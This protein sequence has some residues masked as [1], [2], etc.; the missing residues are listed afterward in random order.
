MDALS[1]IND[2]N[3]FLSSLGISDAD[4]FKMM[5]KNVCFDSGQNKDSLEMRDSE[6][7]GKGVFAIDDIDLDRKWLASFRN[8]KYLCGRV[9]NHSPDPNCKF[10][11]EGDYVFCVPIKKIEAGS[12]LFVN[13]RD[14]VNLESIAIYKQPTEIVEF[15]SKVPS[16]ADWE[17]SSPIDKI[18]YELSTMPSGELPL[19][20]I[21]TEGIYI[22]KAL[23]PAGSIFTT[24][25]HNTEH[26][27][28]LISGT[29]QVISNDGAFRITG[30]F[31]GITKKGTRRLVYAET[32]SVYFTIHANPDN[33]TDPDEIVRK[34]TI[35]IDNPLMD[36]DDP[37]FNT[38]K[39]DI[40]PSQSISTII[41]N[42]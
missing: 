33:L 37:R 5:G 30:P 12:E 26:Q 28:V 39:K 29:T 3:D 23:A 2:Y 38:W 16:L 31:M 7:H 34:I 13:Y 8:Y 9:I 24:V 19:V 17:K 21:F 35:P 11:F 14:N 15:E 25:H 6:I 1:K 18:E 4:A 10:I 40:S 36:N 27:F 22:R 41:T 20:H 32:D 42:K